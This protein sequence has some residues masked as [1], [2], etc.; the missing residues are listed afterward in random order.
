MLYLGQISVMSEWIFQLKR[1]PEIQI[2]ISQI[3][4]LTFHNV[5]YIN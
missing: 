1:I 5:N 4:T 3:D 2:Y